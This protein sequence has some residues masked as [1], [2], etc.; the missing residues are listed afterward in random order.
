MFAVVADLTGL[1]RCPAVVAD[2]T[3]AAPKE[4]LPG[5]EFGPKEV[6]PATFFPRVSQPFVGLAESKRS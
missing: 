6:T 4:P 1:R 3:A 2:Q 5:R